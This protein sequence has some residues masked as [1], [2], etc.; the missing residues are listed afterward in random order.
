MGVGYFMVWGLPLFLP[1]GIYIYRT[2][3]RLSPYLLTLVV[4]VSDHQHK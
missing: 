1:V 3:L 4:P 2:R